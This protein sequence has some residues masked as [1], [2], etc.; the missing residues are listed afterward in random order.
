MAEPAVGSRS[1]LSFTRHSGAS[2]VRHISLLRGEGNAQAFSGAFL[3]MPF[4]TLGLS[5]VICTP[6]RRIGYIHPT[7]VQAKCIPVVITGSDLMARA[8]TGTGKTAAF[9][10]PMIERLLVRDRR[11]ARPSRPRGLVLVPTRELAIQ[12]HNSLASYG[13]AVNVR[14]LAVFGGGTV[15]CERIV[16]LDSEFPRWHQHQPTWP[17]G[18]CG[19]VIANKQALD[20]RQTENSRLAYPGLSPGHQIASSDDNRNA[21]RLNRGGIGIADAEEWSTDHRG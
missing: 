9:G 13:A 12:V 14:A 3:H 7:P 16:N 17:A 8:Q 2:L 4:S 1:R 11:P 18:P 20:H 19:A 21:L 10:L 5:P 15:T 6:L